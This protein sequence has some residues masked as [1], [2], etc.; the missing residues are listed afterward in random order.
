MLVD[1]LH[2]K[3]CL[4]HR[5]GLAHID[6]PSGD[7]LGIWW[8]SRNVDRRVH[9]KVSHV[10][11]LLAATLKDLVER[12]LFPSLS[13]PWLLAHEDLRFLARIPQRRGAVQDA[14]PG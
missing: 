8:Q 1:V 13:E 7:R 14:E 5:V 10:L 6:E 11:E 9:S 12:Q 3:S 2:D 4:D